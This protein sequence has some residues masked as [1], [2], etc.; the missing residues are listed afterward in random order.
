MADAGVD[1]VRTS[2]YSDAVADGRTRSEPDV[3]RPTQ[4]QPCA[5]PLTWSLWHPG[6]LCST[7]AFA[8]MS[9]LMAK[10]G[11][12]HPL[13]IDDFFDLPPQDKAGAAGG[14]LA[15]DWTRQTRRTAAAG[16]AEI[17]GAAG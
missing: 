3:P 11:A 17:D 8:W 7:L 15:L 16:P 6:N 5:H 12:G 2:S 10:G 1:A 4:H 13:G 9:P 14:R